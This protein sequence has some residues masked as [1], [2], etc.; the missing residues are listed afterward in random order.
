MFIL[1]ID[2]YLYANNPVSFTVD[3]P[4]IVRLDLFCHLALGSFNFTATELFG[5]NSTDAVETV[6]GLAS[7]LLGRLTELT[8]G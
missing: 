3:R 6:Q 1:T 5:K 4:D 8:K 7:N 2:R